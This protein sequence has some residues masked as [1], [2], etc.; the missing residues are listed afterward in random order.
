MKK[1]A[2][3]YRPVYEKMED[4]PIYKLHQDRR[5]FVTEI[6]DVTTE[7]L[8]NKSAEVVSDMISKTIYMERIRM[9]EEPWKVDPPNERLFWKRIQKKLIK[10]A[11]DKEEKQ[12]ATVNKEIV[13]SIVNNY[14]E[15]IVSTFQIKTF[16]FARK[17]LTVFFNRL[18]N[19]AAGRNLGRIYSAKYRLFERLK[20]SGEIEKVR[21]LMKKGTVVV[22]P[23]HFSNLDSVLIGY[24]MDAIGGLPHFS[25]AAGLN[26]FNTGYAAYF[27]NRVGPYRVDRRKKN[28]IYLETLKTMSALAIQRGTNSLIFPGGT[29]SRSGE[30]ENK[31]KMGLLGTI[32]EAQRTLCQKG[33]EKKIF[34]VPM[35][36]GYHFVLEAP[37]LIEQHLKN[38][39][40]ERYLK[41]KDNSTSLRKILKFAWKYFSNSSEIF[42]TFG[43]PLDVL[44]NLVDEKGD[45]FDRYGNQINIKDYFLTDGQVKTDLQRER[46]FTK[47][48]GDCIIR[49]FHADNVVLCSHAIAFI[50]F[51]LLKAQNPNLDL[52]GLLR[53]PNEDYVFPIEMVETAMSE[54]QEELKLLAH[55]KKVNLSE[56]IHWPT[57]DLVQEGIKFLGVF[58]AN[59]P[60]KLNKE[61]NVESEDF[62]L[63]YYYHN[64]L[65][66]YGLEQKV[67]WS[68]YKIV[69][70][71]ELEEVL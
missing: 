43:K 60:L 66:H 65:N 13:H 38:T 20:V 61:G 71:P 18:L 51:N 32:M 10:G 53:L 11:L 3:I 1:A 9:K 64:R 2:K 24:I 12:A 4:W 52:F 22:V 17:F 55:A 21:T 49:R 16:R 31:L 5:A 39:G 7:K 34:V 15:E 63:L 19:T 37:F 41:T 69:A 67:N 8:T 50:V 40:K 47:I 28:P 14:A 27:M 45:S 35:I 36:I 59:R 25:Y 58:H 48:L 33:K 23:T 54:L 29:R 62:Y 42:L 30:L 56:E 68:S 57:A 26:L 44:G 6:T 46:E 70:E